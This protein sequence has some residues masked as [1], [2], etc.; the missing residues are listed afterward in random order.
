MLDLYLADDAPFADMP[1]FIKLKTDRTDAG[2]P[3][4]T[5]EQN[6]TY[7]LSL[8]KAAGHVPNENKTVFLGDAALFPHVVQYIEMI[9]SSHDANHN[10]LLEKAEALSAF[11]IFK[12]L[13]TVLAKP[14]TALKEPDMPGVFIYLL[15]NG[16]PPKT[17]KEKLV[18]AKFVKDHDCSKLPDTPC[19]V[20]WDIL[21]TRHD[22]GKIFNFIA[23]ATKPPPPNAS[24][25]VPVAP[26]D[27]VPTSVALPPATPPADGN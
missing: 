27:S 1:D 3:K 11:P 25:G 17:L 5:P 15:K 12:S 26:A 14:F 21:S 13:I 7:Y 6:K 16:R 19:H 20:G 8:L 4:Y 2:E 18:F 10:G 24:D 22:L 23:E 9:Y